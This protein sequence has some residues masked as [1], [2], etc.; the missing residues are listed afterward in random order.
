MA[1]ACF[2]PPL[3]AA[4]AL[5]GTAM[6]SVAGC[7]KATSGESS[8]KIVPGTICGSAMKP[9]VA[10]VSATLMVELTAP[11]GT[12]SVA[13]PSAEATVAPAG[14]TL[15]DGGGMGAPSLPPPPHAARKAAS[16]A[17][18][19]KHTVCGVA[20]FFMDDSSRR[21]DLHGLWSQ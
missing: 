8:L 4:N 7:A 18:A 11:A 1:C 9:S 13:L 19:T 17:E 5:S 14:P 15:S 12:S 10:G 6:L 16:R 3:E 2:R 20:G 21:V